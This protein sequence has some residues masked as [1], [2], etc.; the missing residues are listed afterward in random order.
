MTTASRQVELNHV[1][2]AQDILVLQEIVRK[3]PV[4][5]HVIRYALRLTRSTRKEKGQVP[6]FV[7]DFVSWGC[8]PRASQYLIL[9]GKARALLHKR[10]YVSTDD[11][12]T[13]AH[14]VLRHRIITNFNAEAEGVKPDH[15]IDRL[16]AAI[17]PDRS[18]DLDSGKLPKVFAAAPAAPAVAEAIEPEAK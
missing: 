7:R 2:S 18:D 1:L 4:A 12:R 9:A 11:I 10:Y 8:G 17:R 3:V 13:V 6:D 5:D 14:P 15:I 16:L